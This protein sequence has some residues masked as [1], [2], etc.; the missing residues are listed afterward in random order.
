MNNNQ[1]TLESLPEWQALLEHHRKTENTHMRSLFDKD[2][3]RFSNHSIQYNDILF[4]FSKNR[5][6][7]ETIRLLVNLAKACNLGSAIENMFSGKQIN[8]TEQRSVLHTALRSQSNEPLIIDGINVRE[9]IEIE[10]AKIREVSHKIRQGEWLGSTGKPI[11]DLVNIGIGGSH[12]GPQMVTEALKPFI[13]DAL[14]VHFVANIDENDIDD[15][16]AKL[17]PT[18]TLFVICSKTFTTQETMFNATTARNW[19]LQ[20]VK[21][22]SLLANHFMAVSTNLDATLDFGIAPENVFAIWDWVGGRY[23]IWSAIG[24]SAMLAIGPENFEQL[25]LGAYQVDEHLKHQPFEQN[26]PVIMA[27]LGIW[28]NNF[29]LAESIAVLPYPQHLH[30]FPAYLQQADMESN[31]KSVTASGKSLDYST[32]PVLFGELGNPGQHAFYQ[33]L[34]QGSKLVPIDVL[35][36][37]ENISGERKHQDALISNVFAQ[38]EA[39]MRGKSQQEAREELAQSGLS[40]EEIENLVPHKEFK[41]NR[42]SNTFLFKKLDPK[43]LGS[44]IA[45]YEHKIFVQGIIWDINSFDQWGVE[46]GKQLAKTIL[47]ELEND[48]SEQIEAHDSSTTGLMK[49]YLS[50]IGK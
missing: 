44:L 11:N 17:D 26:I 9:D 3:N 15:T 33:L 47:T 31:G 19:V 8:T 32:G 29:Y 27:L 36:S 28:Y 38:T 41:G 39:L 5:I 49:H 21:D 2:P 43:T 7:E 23:S 24:I 13:S 46:L 50:H 40:K 18:T 42:P 45:L 22:E 4:D 35:A 6:T 10:L 14:R 12:L 25:L 16:L 30:R 48:T 34:H 1:P 20:T 37:I